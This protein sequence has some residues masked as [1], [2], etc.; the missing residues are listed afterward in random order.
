MPR[1]AKAAVLT[2]AFGPA[3]GNAC[4]NEQHPK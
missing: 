2:A 1:I 3:F 4:A